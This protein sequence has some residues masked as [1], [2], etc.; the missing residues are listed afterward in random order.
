MQFDTDTCTTKTYSFIYTGIQIHIGSKPHV[1]IIQITIICHNKLTNE[2]LQGIGRTHVD[3][4]RAN[5]ERSIGLV[6]KRTR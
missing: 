1:I 4:G 3:L 6:Q 5:H 2:P